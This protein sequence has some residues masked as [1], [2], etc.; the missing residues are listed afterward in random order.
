MFKAN[1]WDVL[2]NDEHTT[3]VKETLLAD[4]KKLVREKRG[5]SQGTAHLTFLTHN[6]NTEIV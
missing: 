3:S 6:S 1:W 4:L 5:I 2:N